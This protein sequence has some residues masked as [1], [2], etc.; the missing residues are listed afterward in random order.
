MNN[1]VIVG[2]SGHGKVIADI[3]EKIGYTDIV[4][5]DDNLTV[6]SCGNYVVV[7]ECKEAVSY[8]NA[9]FVVA[10][11]NTKIRRKI[12]SELMETGLRIVSLIHPDAVIAINVQIGVGTVV[13]AGAVVNPCTEIG[14][15]CII[16]T[17]ASVDHDCHIGDYVHVSI[18]AHVAGTVTIRSDTW[19]G[20]GATISNNLEITSGC[21]VGV[22]AVVV[23]DIKEPGTYVG[24]P[25]RRMDMKDNSTRPNS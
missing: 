17:C 10:I 25:A 18:G 19:I 22:G 14:Q 15:G 16:N 13:M 23:N 6:K 8:K 12:Q 2:A 4:F 24:V 1:L 5:L 20:A 9:D 21:M 11:G 3:A 7:G